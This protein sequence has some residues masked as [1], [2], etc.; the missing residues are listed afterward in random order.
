MRVISWIGSIQKRFFTIRKSFFY[1][2]II[3]PALVFTGLTLAQASDAKSTVETLL[4]A[5]R[6]KDAV[7]IR[8]LVDANGSMQYGNGLPKKGKDFV[9]WIESDV[10]AAE[11]LVDNAVVTSRSDGI[12]VTGIIRN[13]RGYSNKANFLFSVKAGKITRW[14]IRY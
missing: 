14:H 1:T 11:A 7:T 6:T 8:L 13:N 2:L 3:L 9:A 4:K 12:V 10:I 5:M